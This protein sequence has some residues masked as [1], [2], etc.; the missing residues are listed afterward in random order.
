M[1]APQQNYL[2]AR[3]LGASALTSGVVV[4]V[5]N[6]LD[7]LRVRWQ[8]DARGARTAGGYIRYLAGMLEAQTV[9]GIWRCGCAANSMAIAVSAGLRMGLYP[10]VRDALTDGSGEKTSFAM[11]TAGLATGMLGYYICTPLYQAKVLL[12]THNPQYKHTLDVM[13]TIVRE[14][15]AIKLYRGPC[16]RM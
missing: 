10:H 15:G 8:T 9:G 2:V 4:A 14:E 7:V 6:P 12:Q 13:C 16:H 3:G 5:F 11:T 1:A